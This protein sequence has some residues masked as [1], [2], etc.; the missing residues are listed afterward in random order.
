MQ[1]K[2][3]ISKG[4]TI[5]ITPDLSVEFFHT[6]YFDLIISLTSTHPISSPPLHPPNFM[7]SVT[8]SLLSPCLSTKKNKQKIEKSIQ[9]KILRKGKKDK[10][11]QQKILSH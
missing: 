9:T 4:S 11:Q 5:R 10:Q 2:K 7:F 3:V 8:L 6:I 1:D